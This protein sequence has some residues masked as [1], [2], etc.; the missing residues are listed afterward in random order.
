MRSVDQTAKALT[1]LAIALVKNKTRMSE[2]M[3][4]SLTEAVHKTVMEPERM[5]A[6]SHNERS[7][8]ADTIRNSR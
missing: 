3:R 7:V 5:P 6:N 1:A 8:N 2:Q 4:E